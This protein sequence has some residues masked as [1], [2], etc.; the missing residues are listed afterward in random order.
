MGSH[1][2]RS[3]RGHED[4]HRANEFR[5]R[6]RTVPVPV[7]DHSFSLTVFGHGPDAERSGALAIGRNRR[8]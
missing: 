5:A 3:N 1:Q 8:G 6:T 4:R 2:R 7:L